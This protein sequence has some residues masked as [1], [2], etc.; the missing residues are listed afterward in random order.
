MARAAAELDDSCRTMRSRSAAAAG[1]A[2]RAASWKAA[3]SIASPK[4]ATA[5]RSAFVS[6]AGLHARVMSAMAVKTVRTRVVTE[7]VVASEAAKYR[8]GSSENNDARRAEP[9]VSRRPKPRESA[10][11][12]GLRR[13]LTRPTSAGKGRQSPMTRD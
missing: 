7:A 12:F 8:R 1:V 13:P 3:S 5:E 2:G 9:L 10:S 11:E 4:A 6:K